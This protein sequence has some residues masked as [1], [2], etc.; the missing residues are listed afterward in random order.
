MAKRIDLAKRRLPSTIFFEVMI[1]FA[2]PSADLFI[3]DDFE[4]S[5]ALGRTTHLGV[6]AHQDDLE[7]MALHGILACYKQPQKWFGG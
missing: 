4:P 2:N 1:Q 3:P 6:G 5:Q 7:V